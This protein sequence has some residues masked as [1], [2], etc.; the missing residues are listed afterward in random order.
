MSHMAVSASDTWSWLHLR[1]AH[2]GGS[3][4][5]ASDWDPVRH[6][7]DLDWVPGLQVES[8]WRQ[9]KPFEAAVGSRQDYYSLSSLTFTLTQNNITEES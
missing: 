2:L 5:G 8:S 6:M 3:R 7:G 9:V 1:A 4:D